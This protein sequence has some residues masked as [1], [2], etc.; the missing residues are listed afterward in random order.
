MRRYRVSVEGSSYVIDVD[1]LSAEDFRVTV[2]EREFRVTLSAAEDIAE[3]VIS[4]EF[5][6]RG[7]DRAIEPAVTEGAPSAARFR[8][9]PP[10]TLGA[11]VPAAPPPLPPAANG[12]VAGARIVKAP[13]PGTITAISVAAG[14]TVRA[15]D[16]LLTLEAMKMLNAIR[17][18]RNGVVAEIA[19]QSGQSVGY[20]QVLVTFG[21]P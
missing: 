15:G 7:D 6:G 16:V 2:G 13:M 14:A 18:P 9:V 17:S 19:V 21:E 4:P 11:M 12:V 20:G 10:E 5:R 8:P 3:A 1:E